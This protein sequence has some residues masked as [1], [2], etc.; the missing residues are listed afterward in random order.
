MKGI[1]RRWM[2]TISTTRT[3]S[4]FVSLMTFGIPIFLMQHLL[5]AVLFTWQQIIPLAIFNGA[6]TLCISAC[7]FFIYA[8]G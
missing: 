8:H 6:A 5:F 1:D 4:G 7:I 2:A 3:G